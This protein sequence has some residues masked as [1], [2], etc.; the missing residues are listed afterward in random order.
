M[1][2]TYEND[3]FYLDGEPHTIV[4]G[5]I[6]Y[7]RVPREYW[8]DRLAKL[9]ACG[10]NAVE[11]YTCWNLH[12]RVQGSFDFSGNLDL[13]AYIDE[14]AKV[15]LHVILRPGPYICA[16]WE[17]GG[18]PSWL[19]TIPHLP[20]RCYDERFI[21]LV[22]RY[23]TALFGHIKGRL[24]CDGGNVMM[25]QVEN[26][27][28]SYGNDHRYMKA[29]ADI[30]K[31]LGVDVPLFTS[32]GPSDFMFNGGTIPG[33]LAVANYG[34]HSKEA[35]DFLERKR[36]GQPKMCGEFWDGWFDHW[37][38]E[39]HVRTDGSDIGEMR[40]ML[41]LG[42]NFNMYMFHGGTNFGFTNG[43]NHPGTY[44]PTV[45]SYDYNAPLNEAGDMTPKYYAIKAMLEDYFGK[46]PELD[47]KN[48]VKIAYGSFA[49]SAYAPLLVNLAAFPTPVESAK[50]MTMEELGQD[51]GF[52]YYKTTLEGPAK[53]ES[54]VIGEPRDRVH[55]IV[56]GKVSAIAERDRRDEKPSFSI[57]D[58]ET[59]ELGLLVENMG[60]VNFGPNLFDEKG[61]LRGVRVGQQY[62]FGWTQQALR[63]E[64]DELAKLE[65]QTLPETPDANPAFYRFN[66]K[67]D[68]VADTFLR[69]E[70][71]EHGFVMLNGHN[72]GRYYYSA[73]PTKTLYVPAPWLIEGENELVVF[74]TDGVKD[75][76]RAV[77]VD[78]PQL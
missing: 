16:E 69:L 49:P 45:T 22:D 44:Q 32:D 3:K 28:G 10:F 34:S 18:L 41:D 42:G 68:R 30:Y 71:F 35:F 29:V 36:P 38:E 1:K 50:P 4:S 24:A 76:C 37:Y 14:A 48:S 52:T 2:L 12:E 63:M 51:F 33:I 11:T 9:R 26:E 20:L 73:G 60:R 40:T 31:E 43:A 59:L 74:E 70:G 23:Y 65:W 27:Y 67:I 17:F 21:K 61:L 19:L 78:E 25:V 66:V 54:L 57:A 7:F 5:T 75:D 13:A 56:D 6:H 15:G 64:T 62:H 39:H 8:H 46:A 72:L 77:F 53:G 55:F 58:G 47:V